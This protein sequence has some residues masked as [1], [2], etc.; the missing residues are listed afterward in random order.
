VPRQTQ[1]PVVP[2]VDLF[3]GCGGITCG[4]V[5]AS[6]ARAVL[7]ISAAVEFD[8]AAAATYAVNYG[9]HVYYGKIED[10][11]RQVKNG[12]IQL[13]KGGIVVGGPP[14][15]GFSGLGKQDT[16]D[17][18]N[19]LWRAY[20]QAVE[21]IEPD[22]F[23]MENVPQFVKSKEYVAL[24]KRFKRSNKLGGYVLQEFVVSAADHGAAQKRRRAIIIGR[25]A[26]LPAVNL[27]KPRK[28]RTLEDAIGHL[29]V[30]AGPKPMIIPKTT[31]RGKSIQGPILTK[32]LHFEGPMSAKIRKMVKAVPPGGS[33]YDLPAD[34][35][36][37]CWLRGTYNGQDVM[38]R[39]SWDKPS[40]TIR[41]QFYKPD[42]GRY[43]HPD[44]DRAIT[45][46]EAAYIQGFPSNYQWCGTPAQIAKQIGNAV[47]VP[48]AKALFGAILDSYL[49][50]LG[51]GAKRSRGGKK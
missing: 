46:A 6:K 2:V 37:D 51:H 25:K 33:R 15:Q 16:K 29:P 20:I 39:L 38:G 4:A 22:Y 10:W 12:K 42:K 48:L 31:Y 23:L 34:L 35:Q 19:R 13:Q 30:S 3:A 18:R 21:L 50:T 11:V 28:P 17:P 27:P 24:K 47:P 40:V 36:Y 1:L 44:E 8:H 45:Y 26:G 5:A 9:D 43:I 14:C 7:N 41:T 49:P 32:L